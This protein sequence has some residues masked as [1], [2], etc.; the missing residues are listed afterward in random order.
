PSRPVSASPSLPSLAPPLLRFRFFG[1]DPSCRSL[2]ALFGFAASLS[3]INPFLD[4]LANVLTQ[5]FDFA[6]RLVPEVLECSLVDPDAV[7]RIAPHAFPVARSA[8]ASTNFIF[9]V[10]RQLTTSHRRDRQRT[11]RRE[12]IKN[13]CDSGI[14]FFQPRKHSVVLIDTESRDIL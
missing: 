5:V 11:A 8:A 3:L 6:R 13:R 2:A 10:S 4:A 12:R 1:V 7:S 9:V 14:D